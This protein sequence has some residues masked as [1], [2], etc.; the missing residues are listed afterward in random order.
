MILT[1][2]SLQSLL[3][4]EPFI[5][6][7]HK[8]AA[9][10]VFPQ[11]E[12]QT[13]AEAVAEYF[14]KIQNSKH[15]KELLKED[16]IKDLVVDGKIQYQKGIFESLSSA[17]DSVKPRFILVTN[18]LRELYPGER[19]KRALNIIK[20]MEEKGADV[21][22]LPVVHDIT[23]NAKEGKIFRKKL[24]Q[25]FDAQLIM[26]GADI[27]PFLYGEQV[28]YARGLIRKRDV[29]ELK[30][31]RQFIEAEKGMNY[32]ICRGHQMCAVANHKKLIQDIQIQEAAPDLHLDGNHP[33]DINKKSDIFSIFNKKKIVVNSYHHQA[34][35]V[36]AG[37]QEYKVIAKSLDDRPIVEA[38]EFRNGLG[39][40]LQFHP[41]LMYDKTGDKILQQFVYLAAKNK[42]SSNKTTCRSLV[43][44][45][46]T[47]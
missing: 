33:I 43:R 12:G 1:L 8:D 45:I 13:K 14:E 6:R 47:H 3:A 7:Q 37:D 10:M 16:Q 20:R 24:I 39:V 23:L 21:L 38:I 25:A 41:E 27:D 42:K 28:S 11:K 9:P 5:W 46:M 29:S 18:E 17:A 30:F 22:T 44:A 32:G 19:G 31:V 2:I 40:S 15:L 34:V 36:A 35:Y 4:A 26:G